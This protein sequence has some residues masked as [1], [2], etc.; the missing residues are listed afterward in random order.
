MG[1]W[2]G[3]ALGLLV[4]LTVV[5]VVLLKR[6]TM[7]PLSEPNAARPPVTPHTASPSPPA[8]M[9]EAPVVGGGGPAKPP[10]VPAA[11]T[12][13]SAE[14]SGPPSQ[15]E[16]ETDSTPTIP[17]EALAAGR[18]LFAD[19]QA[20]ARGGD[21]AAAFD[22][23][24]RAWALLRQFPDDP[25]CVELGREVYASLAVLAERADQSSQTTLDESKPLVLE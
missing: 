11:S 3:V 4:L 20:S 2:F 13:E 8:P 14:G 5:A 23:A 22:E 6:Q 15:R 17:E 12:T 25:A 19:S 21:A 7:V 10:T 16:S 24:S 9:A 18:E 1:R